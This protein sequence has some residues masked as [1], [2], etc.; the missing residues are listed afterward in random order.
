[1]YSRYRQAF[2]AD[3]P[4]P[5]LVQG[6]YRPC[7]LRGRRCCGQTVYCSPAA[8]NN[9]PSARRPSRHR[10]I[11]PMHQPCPPIRLPAMASGWLDP[12][13]GSIQPSTKY[14]KHRGRVC[15]FTF[16]HD[17]SPHCTARLPPT[18]PES[19]EKQDSRIRVK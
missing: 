14:G 2:Q 17:H 16:Q 5:Q 15:S 9:K 11:R 4:L 18:R 6:T 13:R 1:M 7:G 19:N 10:A 12:M 8:E 3:A